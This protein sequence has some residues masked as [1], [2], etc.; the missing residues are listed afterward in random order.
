MLRGPPAARSTLIHVVHTSD[1]SSPSLIVAL[2]KARSTT[3]GHS[4]QLGRER[5]TPGLCSRKQS[6]SNLPGTQD[7]SVAGI[8]IACVLTC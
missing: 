5:E 4:L 8:A 2:E 7:L 3:A 1:L 6:V